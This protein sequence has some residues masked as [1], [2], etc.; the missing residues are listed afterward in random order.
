MRRD[1]FLQPRVI[2]IRFNPFPDAKQREE[3]VSRML[4][5]LISEYEPKPVDPDSRKLDQTDAPRDV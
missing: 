2:E 1:N 3:R 4:I 5:R